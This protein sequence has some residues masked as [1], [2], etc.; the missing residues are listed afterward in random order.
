[1]SMRK[2][3]ITIYLSLVFVSVLL[4]ISIITE[5]AR[6][7][8]VQTECKSFTYL[9]SDSVLAGYARQVYEDYGVLLV[10]EDKALK[11]QLMKYLQA[12]INLA[13][14][15]IGGTNIMATSLKDIN[16][17][18]TRYAVRNGGEEFI[19]QVLSYM[20]YAIA[21]E[22]VN[23]LVDL[24]SDSSSNQEE[25]DTSEYMVN[26][27][28]EDNSEI[29][30]IVDEINDEISKLKDKNIKKGLK[31]EKKR[32]KFLKNINE[33]IEKLERYMEEKKEFL[34][35]NKGL[36]GNDYM[37]SNLEI[38]EQIKDRIEKEE[39]IDSSASKERWEHIGEEITEQIKSLTV[40]IAT[41]EDEKN[42]GIYES[43]TEFLEKGILS[44]VIDDTSNI[45]SA[46]ISDSNLPSKK[47]YS[48]KTPF[49]DMTDK[50]KMVMYAGMKFGNYRN[51]KK[52]SDLSYEMEYIIAGKDSDRSNL[53]AVVEQM[54][55]IR[56]IATLAYL[57]TDQRKMAELSSIASSASIAIGLPFLEPVIK[58]ILTEAWALAEAVNDVK[59][60]M[61]GKKIDLTKDSGN[62]K[63][64]LAHLLA[65]KTSGSDKK[66]AI[67]YQQFCYLLM[68]KESINTIAV[69]MLDI[70]QVNVK[71]NYN[72]SFDINQCFTGFHMEAVY[73]SQPLFVSMPWTIHSLGEKIGAYT[74][75][76]KCKVEY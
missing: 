63:T 57:L 69:R 13:D 22:T 39:L 26:V 52:K 59:I 27:D 24:Y 34:K 56:N 55:G 30:D 11:E 73:E 1:M 74:F 3:S 48:K 15:N 32:T 45:S 36:S 47:E 20:K 6:L 58:G 4:L 70:I 37:D 72:Q 66:G 61:A 71:K 33:I 18:E 38:L 14:L 25:S 40:N 29:S 43:A 5:S 17:K 44:I 60:I 46:S 65:S 64:S 67:N 21:T 75:S 8:V 68:M 7:N 62:W 28:E 12:N 76:V 41:E 9:A 50:A 10:W 35:E 2:G 49:S 23:K 53:T 51:T 19:N 16:I 31:T 42:K 54:A